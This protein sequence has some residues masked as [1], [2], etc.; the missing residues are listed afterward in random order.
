[1]TRGYRRMVRS[2]GTVAHRFSEQND[3]ES[4]FVRNRASPPNPL[5]NSAASPLRGEGEILPLKRSFP[6][7]HAASRSDAELE[8]GLGG[9]A[10]LGN[11]PIRRLNRHVRPYHT[12]RLTLSY[13][14]LAAR[15][16]GT[17]VRR[18]HAMAEEIR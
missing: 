2:Y 14:T 9:E 12:A 3:A 16:R 5:S 8:R 7:L 4:S 17:E 1:M 15:C 10:R 6:P 13:S 11:P 18:E